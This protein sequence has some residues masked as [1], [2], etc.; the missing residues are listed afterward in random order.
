MYFL[1][2]TDSVSVMGRPRRGPAPRWRARY[3]RPRREARV[4]PRRARVLVRTLS[5]VS[6][7]SQSWT[8]SLSGAMDLSNRDA[9]LLCSRAHCCSKGIDG[10]RAGTSSSRERCWELSSAGEH[11]ALER[12]R[13]RAE[14]LREYREG[15]C[16]RGAPSWVSLGEHDSHVVFGEEREAYQQGQLVLGIVPISRGIRPPDPR[17]RRLGALVSGAEAGVALASDSGGLKEGWV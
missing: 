3:W 13:R 9:R 8:G 16:G 12:C 5:I 1:Q 4:V 17:R 15:S 14:S 7:S 11:V 10:P 6:R 2:R